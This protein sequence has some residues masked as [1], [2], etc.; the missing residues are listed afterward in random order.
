MT[1]VR[2]KSESQIIILSVQGQ[3]KKIWEDKAESENSR[4]GQET[5]T[6][7]KNTA[8]EHSKREW[9]KIWGWYLS[10]IYK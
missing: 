3:D 2:A 9:L 6:R 4:Y 8:E 5:I 10:N 1:L 7:A